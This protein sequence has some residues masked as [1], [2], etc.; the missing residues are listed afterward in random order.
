M[1][2]VSPD[3]LREE[4]LSETVRGFRVLYDTSRKGFK[5]K[6]V[7]KNAW[8]GIVTPLEFIQTGNFYFNSYFII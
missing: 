6:D 5:E 4:E 1:E 3:I 8:N 7:V 2:K